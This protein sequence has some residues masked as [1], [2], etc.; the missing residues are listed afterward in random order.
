[1]TQLP[2]QVNEELPEHAVL[3]LA[4][5]VLE[6]GRSLVQTQVF[7]PCRAANS[8]PVEL[9]AV[10]QLLKHCFLIFRNLSTICLVGLEL[11]PRIE[12]DMKS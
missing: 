5:E 1:M 3:Q 6:A 4:S 11:D 9:Q 2:P 8:Y 10:M 12:P 7:P